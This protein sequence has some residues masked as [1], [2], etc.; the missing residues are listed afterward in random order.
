[1]TPRKLVSLIRF[2]VRM[3]IWLD[4][5][6]SLMFVLWLNM[7]R[8]LI[9]LQ[10]HLINKTR[11]MVK[12]IAK[13]HKLLGSVATSLTLNKYFVKDVFFIIHGPKH[14]EIRAVALGMP[15]LLSL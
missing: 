7:K 9:L 13:L 2:G 14:G 4:L 8:A 10:C 5:F 12:P 3:M 6:T 15:R 1:M 11:C